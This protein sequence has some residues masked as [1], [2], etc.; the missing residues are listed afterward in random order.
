MGSCERVEAVGAIGNVVEKASIDWDVDVDVD[1]DVRAESAFSR[2]AKQ[3][4]KALLLSR[5]AEATRWQG[6]SGDR[7]Q[8]QQALWKSFRQPGNDPESSKMNV[9]PMG[10][11]M[12]RFRQLIEQLKTI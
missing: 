10:R 1:V 8:G 11:L 12:R 6:P 5:R 9:D 4:I 3:A 2:L 7:T